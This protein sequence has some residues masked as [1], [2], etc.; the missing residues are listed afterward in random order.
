MLHFVQKY[1]NLCNQEILDEMINKN[2]W[3]IVQNR[4]SL[5][6][7]PYVCLDSNTLTIINEATQH[8]SAS[9]KER[10]SRLLKL[11]E[12]FLQVSGKKFSLSTLSHVEHHV[13]ARLFIGALW[14]D[15]FMP[16][17]ITTRHDISCTFYDIIKAMQ[18]IKLSLTIPS[19][20]I[21]RREVT[22]DLAF[23][24]KEFEAL[25]LNEERIYYWR[26]WWAY[27]KNNMPWFVPLNSVYQCYGRQFTDRLFDQI[28]LAYLRCNRSLA[29]GISDFCR[30]LPQSGYHLVQFQNSADVE[31]LFQDFFVHYLAAGYKNG[32]GSTVKHLVKRWRRL[33]GFIEINL[34]GSVFAKPCGQL[35]MPKPMTIKG[36]E[37]RVK[38]VSDGIDVK[39]KLLTDVPLH[40]TDEQAIE[41]LFKQIQTDY[42]H[43]VMTAEREAQDLWERYQRRKALAPLGQVKP[44]K[45]ITTVDEEARQWFIH[46]NN[47]DWL[48]NASATFESEGF[49]YDNNG[50]P[51]VCSSYSISVAEMVYALGL[52]KHYALIPYM[53][54]LV[55]EHPTIVASF[56]TDFELYNKQGKLTGFV[57]LDDVW[58]LD[59]R[60]RRCKTG[61]AQQIVS[62]N[63]KSKR[64]VEQII[65][66][67]DCVRQHLKQKGDDAWRYL[68]LT[69]GKGFTPARMC[70][71]Y[72]QA[73]RRNPKGSFFDA[74]KN[75][76]SD[77]TLEGTKKLSARFSLGALRASK[78]V[79][80]YL[81][82]RSV[83]E[84]ANAL[85]H[86][87][88]SPK[89]LSHYLP[90]PIFDFFQSRW[91]RIFQQGI[92]IEAM[93]NSA[94]LLE[95]TEFCTMHE[96]HVFMQNH[97]LK[98]IPSHLED[99][100]HESR[101]CA[102]TKISGEVIF[103]VNTGILTLLLSLQQAVAQAKKRVCGKAIYWSEMARHLI[104]HIEQGSDHVTGD[105]FKSYLKTAREKASPIKLE[106]IIYG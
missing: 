103:N 91:I 42:D 74:L 85:G 18:G 89:T 24:I 49:A 72:A 101:S 2:K 79:L 22:S 44:Y 21:D 63:A 29:T 56:L 58:V 36:S 34:L 82:T 38:T 31:K 94:L 11:L 12:C 4:R 35:V 51:L 54:L 76:T 60:K 45:W 28:S 61:N 47:P 87:E 66:L 39:E 57:Q 23:C 102:S 78:G 67:T 52:P 62:L 20:K 16:A 95:A 88:Y 70:S 99:P 3:T 43:V 80:V 9:G 40:V 37:M 55:S 59:G 7:Y 73:R 27:N 6:Y 106:A 50:R 17:K 25:S 10:V 69:S 71:Q 26:G 77:I 1:E 105:E 92:I 93:K 86:K 65:A 81:E 75:P 53:V 68:F 32:E 83:K 90:T 104:T 30:W 100:D 19:I 64:W 5:Q 8:F 97:A 33:A 15:L 41:L 13:T 98:T 84:M 96:F 14:S 46:K 48:L